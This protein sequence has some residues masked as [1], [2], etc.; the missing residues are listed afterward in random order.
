MKSVVVAIALL[1]FALSA[2]LALSARMVG[3]VTI[4]PGSLLLP[5]CC[6]VL[7]WFRSATGIAISSFVVLLSW[8]A[9][10][11]GLP[12]VS[13][14]MPLAAALLLASPSD[15]RSYRR[16]GFFLRAV[17]RAM[18][19]PLFTLLMLVLHQISATTPSLQSFAQALSVNCLIANARTLMQIS[20]IAIPISAACS[21]M[22]IAADELGLRRS[23]SQELI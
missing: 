20:I 15:S 7:F 12:L 4:L 19:L 21:L 14:L 22:I 9:R 2:E 11:V 13:I 17:P 10:P 3:P 18:H 1:W 8:M 23:I 6:A 5:L 16:P